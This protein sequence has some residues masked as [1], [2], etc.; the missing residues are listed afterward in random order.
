[1]TL[2]GCVRRGGRPSLSAAGPSASSVPPS[3]SATYFGPPKQAMSY[4]DTALPL[5]LF[6]A[7]G[8]PGVPAYWFCALENPGELK[9]GGGFA[10]GSSH[11]AFGCP[12]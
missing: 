6:F 1:M 7:D 12:A 2:T 4:W 5:W 3:G 9:P 8:V 10:P 11:E